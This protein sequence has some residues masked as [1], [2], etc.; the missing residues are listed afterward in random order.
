MQAPGF[1]RMGLVAVGLEQALFVG[2][3]GGNRGF[4]G[5]FLHKKA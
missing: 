1:M 2:R 5:I 3:C 4:G